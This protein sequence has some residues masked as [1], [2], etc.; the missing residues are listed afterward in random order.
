M[1]AQLIDVDPAWSAEPMSPS[2]W[3]S[4]VAPHY[5]VDLVPAADV[6][7]DPAPS[8]DSYLVRV[9]LDDVDEGTDGG[10]PHLLAATVSNPG[11]GGVLP[12]NRPRLFVRLGRDLFDDEFEALTGRRPD[13]PVIF[14]TDL[15][16][17]GPGQGLAAAVAGIVVQMRSQD[18]VLD[19]P[20]LRL[21]NLRS[22][23][24]AMLLAQPNNY[25]AVL[26]SGQS[27]L[28]PRHLRR[29][30]EHISANLQEELRLGSLAEAA[31]CSTRT[32]NSTFREHLGVTP[33]THVRNL[34]LDAVRAEIAAGNDLISTVAYTWGFGHMGRFAAL[35]ARRFGELP[36]QTATRGR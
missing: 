8:S 19:H 17:T 31:G 23:V 30:M 12:F 35:Y 16:L 13:G 21:V 25:S 33:M 14:E 11:R 4:R 29:A 22:L 18:R 3:R 1:T 6:A 24:S 15:K 26:R 36:S 34:R 32:L 10:R 2:P 5:A 27:P 20:H 7:E 9:V 28:R